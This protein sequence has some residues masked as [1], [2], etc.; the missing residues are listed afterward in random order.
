MTASRR[1][2]DKR[3]TGTVIFPLTFP[4]SPTRCSVLLRQHLT[5]FRASSN[6]LTSGSNERTGRKSCLRDRIISFCGT[7]WGNTAICFFLN[8]P[9]EKETCYLRRNKMLVLFR[10]FHSSFLVADKFVKAFLNI[11]IDLRNALLSVL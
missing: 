9:T 11:C 5:L 1:K 8:R 4:Q 7:S 3:K 10:L 6:L 2:L